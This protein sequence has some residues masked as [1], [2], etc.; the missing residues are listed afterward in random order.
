MKRRNFL[1]LI[2]SCVITLSNGI[3]IKAA[4]IIKKITTPPGSINLENLLD[5]CI[6]CNE[7]I[8]NCPSEVLQPSTN[9]YGKDYDQV[10]YLDFSTNFCNYTCNTC[11]TIC[12]T[13][14]IIEL[15]LK[16]KQITQIGIAKFNKSQ[17][18]VITNKT[19]C[20]ACAEV[21][22]TSAIILK[23]IGNNLEIP[24]IKEELCIGCGACE[25]A[26]PV[27]SKDAIYTDGL[28]VHSLAKAIETKKITL[29]PKT[30]N[31]KTFAF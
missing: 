10:P 7:C 29:P 22:P 24:D 11:S 3:K 8:D 31:G 5:N 26:C 18:I 23:D 19:S 30:K 1:Q 12:P 2:A 15:P 13:D 17:C 16:K 27:E 25:F 6:K 14:A 4:E 9:Q 20:G 21:C 28:Q